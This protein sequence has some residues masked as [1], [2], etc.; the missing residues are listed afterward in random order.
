MADKR[1]AVIVRLMAIAS[2]LTGIARVTRNDPVIG[3]GTT[4]RPLVQIWDGEEVASDGDPV[5]RRRLGQPRVV[6]MTPH[7]YL[8]LA[9]DPA[10]NIGTTINRFVAAIKKAV[11]T[12]ATLQ[13]I[14]GT[15][16]WIAYVASGDP[17]ITRGRT[18]EAEVLISFSFNYILVPSDL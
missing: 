9:E 12:D 6:G 2:G 13:G 16:G 18:I 5:A 3:E 7:I 1:E 8:M 14:L 4:D 17:N 15:T 11:M 10:E